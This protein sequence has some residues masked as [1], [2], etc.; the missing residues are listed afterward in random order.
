M[1]LKNPFKF[2][3][4]SSTPI[5][6]SEIDSEL[7]IPPDSD[8]QI[9]ETTL[10]WL[11]TIL[12]T[13][14]V[15]S[16]LAL[17][18]SD[19]YQ[20]DVASLKSHAGKVLIDNGLVRPEPKEALIFLSGLFT[21]PIGL[22]L[23]FRFYSK[24]LLI[25]KLPNTP[26]F[27]I[28]A[29][30]G[31]M[32]LIALV[33]SDF[34]AINPFSE[35]AGDTPIISRDYAGPT[36]FDFYFKDLFLGNHLLIYSF[37]IIP[38]VA[39]LFFIGF[40]QHQLHK[41]KY[42]N[43]IVSIIGYTMV[44]G[45]I[46][47]SAIM[48]TFNF[49]YQPENKLDFSA[50]YYSMTQV[51]AG[52]PMLTDGFTNAYG[53]YPHFLHPL[54][55]IIGLSVFKFSL[56][57]A[58]L[59]AIAFTLNFYCLAKFVENKVILFLGMFS[60]LFFPFLLFKFTEHF[61]SI[62]A[63]YSIRYIIPSTLLF[64]AMLYLNK[65]TR[66]LYWISF[67]IMASSVLWNPEFGIVCYLSWISFLLFIDLFS[68]SGELQIKKILSHCIVAAATLAL[69]FYA[70]KL[71]VYLFYGAS[72]DM[73]EVW[74]TIVIFGK[75]GFGLLPMSLLH[76]WNLIVLFLILG[77]I[78]SVSNIYHRTITNRTAIV[79]LVFVISTGYFFY[80][81]GRSHNWNLSFCS[82][83][84]FLL[85]TLLADE[86]WRK[87]SVRNIQVLNG[88]FIVFLFV[89]TVSFFEIVSN[90][91]KFNELIS[92]ETD[93]A[94]FNSEM[95]V[96]LGSKDFIS[97]NSTQFQ[98][99]H[100]ITLRKFQALF[101]DGDQRCSAFNPGFTNLFLKKD[102]DRLEKQIV[103]SSFRVFITPFSLSDLEFLSKPMAAFAS[104]YEYTNSNGY[105]KIADK[106]ITRLPI[107]A[108]FKN[109]SEQ[110]TYRK[111]SD[112]NTGTESRINDALGINPVNLEKEF[113]LE[114]LFHSNE[115]VFDLPTLIGN[116]T[117]SSGFAF[118]ISTNAAKC[119]FALNGKGFILPVP[120]NEWVYCVINV[121]PDHFEMYQNGA[122]ITTHP[123]V[124]PF[125]NS[126][127]KLFI[128]NLGYMHYYTGA[129][130]E[131]QLRNKPVSSSHIN[132][133]WNRIRTS[134]AIK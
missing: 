127:M 124:K 16:C 104:A 84:S 88:I 69:V 33:Y 11:F 57:M 18:I 126:A 90:S 112:D 19:I 81:Q 95:N 60:I 53:L 118:G 67:F 86:F 103:D 73:T 72:P 129:I 80:F 26:Y 58:L 75:L 99:I 49:P 109:D 70:F 98:K 10:I 14:L 20:P 123:L 55:S 24:N 125:I 2:F 71:T 128:G 120:K 22:F 83:F 132:D 115:Q 63:F 133:T 100:V 93:K 35:N 38:I 41:H 87:I 34:T 31:L 4:A 65:R 121:Y 101:F 64:L 77:C 43:S 113:S 54:F 30:A 12:S 79:F 15:F 85:I 108:F 36:N 47:A 122:F 29:G 61:D 119:L 39:I 111:Y 5:N 6:K 76:P 51:Y 52:V 74:S 94:N 106:R 48:N 102:L 92:Q 32:G 134:I 13:I 50:V 131:V 37:M 17:L 9:K 116:S 96:V 21:I 62:F 44:G 107:N 68:A 91:G 59:Q 89:I 78:Y 46:I 25:K 8:Y 66:I 110:V 97:K 117:D 23:F 3:A 42:F 1:K 56:V 27:N 114:L 130:S 105:V 45:L 28:I 40:K 7:K 82:G